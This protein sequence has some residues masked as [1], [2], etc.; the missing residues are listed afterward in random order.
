MAKEPLISYNFLLRVEG[1]LDL[2]CRSIKGFEK[3]E[4]YEYIQEGGVNDYV[5][6]RR[7]PASEPNIFQVECYVGTEQDNVLSL[8]TAFSMP[9][10]IL[11]ARY[12]GKFENP[13][14]IFEF[15]GCVVTKKQY[16]ELNAEKGEILTEITTIAYQ[17]VTCKDAKTESQKSVW[18][19]DKT[20]TDGN[21]E[22][23]AR[24]LQSFG[25]Q[26]QKNKNARL[27][28]KVSSAKNI[29]NYLKS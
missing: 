18:K 7:K 12:P 19:F 16:G 4:E 28:P 10:Q 17:T 13:K 11:I 5:H 2:P 21:R 3:K 15:K 14:R 27:W 20:N 22:Q 25:I 26:K 8:G 29:K 6:I 24:T 23:S 1:M 9:M